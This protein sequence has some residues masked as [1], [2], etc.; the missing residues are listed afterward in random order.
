[1]LGAGLGG[2]VGTKIKKTTLNKKTVTVAY[3][4]TRFIFTVQALKRQTHKK[5][6]KTL[7]GRGGAK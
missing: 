2:G 4:V 1:M 6:K 7:P 5:T 3:Q